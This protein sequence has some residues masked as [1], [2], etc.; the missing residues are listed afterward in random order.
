VDKLLVKNDGKL[1]DFGG[2]TLPTAGSFNMEFI[3]GSN[4][5][6]GVHGGKIDLLIAPEIF[7]Q[8]AN[9]KTPDQL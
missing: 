4:R 7:G 2:G 5:F 1:V 3:V 8:T 9:F 6:V